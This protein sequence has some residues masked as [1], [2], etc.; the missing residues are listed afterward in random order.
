SS[1]KLPY[2]RLTFE[3]G[4][5]VN[6]SRVIRTDED[7]EFSIK[8]PLGKFIVNGVYQRDGEKYVHVGSLIV[9][10]DDPYR[11][12]FEPSYKVSGRIF[13]D[14]APEEDIRLLFTNND[15]KEAVVRTNS[16]GNFSLS[17]PPDD[18]SLYG[19]KIEGVTPLYVWE[20]V[21]VESSVYNEYDTEKGSFVSGT[22]YRDL[23]RNGK[24]D[25]GEGIQSGYDM[26]YETKSTSFS[27]SYDGRFSSIVPKENIDI[28]FTREGFKTSTIEYSPELGN[29]NQD[30]S[31]E[32]DNVTLKGDIDYNTEAQELDEIPLEFVSLGQ[33]AIGKDIVVEGTSFTTELQPGDYNIVIDHIEEDGKVKYEF[34]EDLMVGIG[35][36]EINLDIDVDYKVRFSG[37][38]YAESG[39]LTS[40][41]LFFQK[42]T[43]LD[44]VST[45]GSFETYLTPDVY[46]IRAV[47]E[48]ITE[49]NQIK[50]DI[51]EPT[52]L[53]I[54]LER[55]SEFTPSVT[56]DGL[57]KENVPVVVNNRDSGFTFNKTTDPNGEVQFN[58]NPGEYRVSV[59]HTI[60]DSVPN[61]GVPKTVNYYYSRLFSING[62]TSPVIQLESELVN[63]TLSG[64]VLI[65]DSGARETE[66]NF[67]STGPGSLSKTVRT[68][69]NGRFET[70]LL[71][72]TGSY[73]TIYSYYEGSE[74]LYAEVHDFF[75]PREDDTLNISLSPAVKISGRV[76]VDGDGKETEVEFSRTDVG[77]GSKSFETDSDG[78]YEAILPK[79][80]YSVKSS[81]KK[82]EGDDQIEYQKNKEVE[83][84]YNRVLDLELEKV[85]EYGVSISSVKTRKA[86]P[87]DN[88]TYSIS[89]TNTGNT[90]DE[91]KL[92]AKKSVWDIDLEP[93]SFKLKA[94]RSKTIKAVVHVSEEASVDHPPISFTVKY[95]D[96]QE[97]D[98]ELPIDVKQR[99]GLE[100]DEEV[101]KKS[102]ESGYLK[103]TVKVT[104]TGNGDDTFTLNIKNQE[105]LKLK[106]WEVDLKNSTELISEGKSEEVVIELKAMT[107]DPNRNAKINLIGTSQGDQ[108]ITYETSFDIEVPSVKAEGDSVDVAGDKISLEKEEFNLKTWHWGSLVFL[109]IIAAVY[110]L[111]K[112]RWI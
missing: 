105:S 96:S 35:E 18:Y 93:A 75:M 88:L 90:E 107:S 47:N 91:F 42:E 63:N 1:K 109:A 68:D 11:A 56:Y 60:Q 29:Y 23:N 24:Y 37:D 4:S 74:G 79:G 61:I 67:I 27:T 9:P 70:E 102:F 97:K 32:A 28:T 83:L 106:G 80:S 50:R 53:N 59:D 22:V 20:D 7:G 51:E 8:L 15:D 110:I 89:I 38:L 101:T 54:T 41:T 64:R 82:T 77:V 31:L 95:G 49:S 45:E 55:S 39:N 112:K 111:R 62:S 6:Y 48:K 100:I 30:V 98:K 92:D 16:E 5:G 108:S 14:S 58:L 86:D 10:F 44:N 72:G 57:P 87:G 3:G 73:Y 76:T 81:W 69:S 36:E 71:G 43:F 94:G 40:G 103:Y 26:V 34:D 104:N 12:T 99:Y 78:S 21:S 46:S 25:P 33:S 85:K 66:V 65:G 84:S 19:W 13:S 52:E 17:L 2:Q